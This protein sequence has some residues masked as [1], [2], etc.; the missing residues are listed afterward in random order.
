MVDADL[1]TQ[2]NDDATMLNIIASPYC[3]QQSVTIFLLTIQTGIYT[4]NEA[5]TNC[6]KIQSSPKYHRCNLDP[7]L[8]ECHAAELFESKSISFC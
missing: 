1:H 8:P 7:T 5:S 6:C 2:H 3:T 4:D